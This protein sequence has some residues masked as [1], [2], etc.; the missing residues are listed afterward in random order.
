MVSE[1]IQHHFLP[2]SRSPNTTAHSYGLAS[3][4]LPGFTFVW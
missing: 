1:W 4:R 2:L 3:T